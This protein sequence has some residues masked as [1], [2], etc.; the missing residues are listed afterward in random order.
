MQQGRITILCRILSMSR[1][2]TGTISAR[3][4]SIW[5]WTE[6]I[7]V[8]EAI[9]ELFSLQEQVSGLDLLGTNKAERSIYE[10][11]KI[12]DLPMRLK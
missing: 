4:R 11:H 1:I 8:S 3:F 9:D 7:F 12:E 2:P 6:T 5:P 10:Y